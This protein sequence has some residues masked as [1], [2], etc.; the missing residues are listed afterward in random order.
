M[1]E[2]VVIRIRTL[3][4]RAG[5]TGVGLSSLGPTIYSVSTRAK[6]TPWSGLFAR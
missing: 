3:M 2:E 6:P 5:L 4:R 1:Q